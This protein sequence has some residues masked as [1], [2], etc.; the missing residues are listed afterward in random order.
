MNMKKRDPITKWVFSSVL[1]LCL[2]CAAIFGGLYVKSLLSQKNVGKVAGTIHPAVLYD[3][4][5]KGD[6]AFN[7]SAYEDGVKKF[8]YNYRTKVVEV[9]P[10]TRNLTEVVREQARA[11]HSP[12]IALGFSYSNAITTV[13]KEYPNLQFV[14]IDSVVEG[15]N[16]QSIIFKEHEGSYLVGALAALA[17]QTHSVGFVGG[18]DIPL[19][20]KFGC[21]FAQGAK[22]VDPNIRLTSTTLG[23]TTEA[24]ANPKKA[25][26]IATQMFANGV[27]IIF[28]AA[29]GSGEGVYQAAF[30]S[31]N[32]AIAVDASQNW[33]FTGETIISSMLKEVGFA[34]YQS[35]EEAIH[36][37]WKSGT[38][39]LG[40]KE[41]GVSWSLD[42]FN[43][44]KSVKSEWIEQ[45]DEIKEELIDGDVK[46]YDYSNDQ[47]CPVDTGMFAS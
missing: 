28:A 31:G 25:Q 36:G 15:P 18:M 2:I 32:R 19:I 24:F 41:G 20:H 4:A 34:A 26:K 27:D 13:S 33:R 1:A 40:L 37:K 14:I 44:N 38:K 23:T 17:S 46:V 3:G 43:R 45:I 39:L 5:G 10:G 21:G 30:E 35:M 12:I 6:Y 29:G 8:E 16:V 42:M 7:D 11:N 47:T 9:E 22:A